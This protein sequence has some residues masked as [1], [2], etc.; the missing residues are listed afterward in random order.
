MHFPESKDHI[1]NIGC[2]VDMLN[3]CWK[4]YLG[5]DKQHLMKPIH[6]KKESESARIPPTTRTTLIG[7]KFP[8]FLVKSN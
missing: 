5:W 3:I 8:Q 1:G 2:N 6:I 4:G 7:S